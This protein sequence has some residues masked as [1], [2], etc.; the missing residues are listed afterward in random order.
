MVLKDA[1]LTDVIAA[2]NAVEE[3]DIPVVIVSDLLLRL[4]YNEGQ[5]SL[6]RAAEAIRTHP[7]I[8]DSL[9]EQMQSVQAPETHSA[10]TG[11]LD[12]RA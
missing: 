10:I 5:V 3:L 1:T 7:R 9:L 11:S 12:V 4:L 2:A 8:L 6:T